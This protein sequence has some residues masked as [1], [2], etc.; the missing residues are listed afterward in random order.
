MASFAEAKVTEVTE[1]RPDLV[2]LTVATPDGTLA[3]VGFPAMLG[4]VAP[5]DRV[6]VNTTGIELGLGT[7]GVAFVLWSL[8]GAGPEGPG[9]GHIVKLRYTP[10]QLNVMS[11]EAPESPHHHSLTGIRSIDGMPVVTLGLHSQLAPVTA[12]IKAAKPDA[13]VA[14]LMTDGASLPIAWSDA[15]AELRAKDLLDATC[16]AGH[17]FGGELESV[18]VFSGLAALRHVAEADIVIAGMGPGVVGTDTELGF[19]AIEQG[20][21]VDATTGLGGRPIAALRISFADDRARHRGVS[22]HTLTALTVAA[23]TRAAVVAPKL[24]PAQTKIVE[25]QLRA[26]GVCDKHELV[27]ADGRPGLDLLAERG[28]EPRSMGRGVSDT[29]EL[30]LA[31]SAAGRHAAGGL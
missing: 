1:E 4:P 23:Q 8:D 6:I 18:N 9:E 19:S 29:P 27:W 12:G 5:G 3:A 13:R 24:A 17:A 26:S 25:D 20:Q 28:I 31:A 15:V 10:W 14:Y 2:R 22:H 30:F 7:G 16:T 21:L 11:A